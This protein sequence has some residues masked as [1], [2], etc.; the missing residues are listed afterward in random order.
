MLQRVRAWLIVRPDQGQCRDAGLAFTLILLLTFA[1][2]RADPLLPGAIVVLVLAMAWPGIFRP[3]AVLWFGLARVLGA[4]VSRV[5]LI[6]V[7]LA[8]VTPVGL[9]R[10]MLGRDALQLK[11][12]KRGTDSVMRRRQHRYV[13]Q[14]LTNPY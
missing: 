12:F 6:V 3:F 13:G 7:F 8:L 1:F 10:R 11:E 4:F 9:L 5:L 2:T 14:D